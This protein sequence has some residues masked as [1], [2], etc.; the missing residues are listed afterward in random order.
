MNVLSLH[1][2]MQRLLF[3]L[4]LSTHGLLCNAQ[5]ANGSKQEGIYYKI[6]TKDPNA[7]KTGFRRSYLMHLR[8]LSSKNKEIFNTKVLIPKKIDMEFKTPLKKQMLLTFLA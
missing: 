4:I 3:I 2:K 1:A 8:K 5:H 6:F 7:F